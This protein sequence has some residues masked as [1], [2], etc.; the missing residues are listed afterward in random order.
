MMKRKIISSLCLATLCQIKVLFGPASN[1]DR[2]FCDY[3]RT[4]RFR[5]LQLGKFTYRLPRVQLPFKC[6]LPYVKVE[7]LVYARDF[8]VLSIMQ[9]QPTSVQILCCLLLLCSL[10][11]FLVLAYIAQH[12]RSIYNPSR[13]VISTFILT[14]SR[15]G[16][17]DTS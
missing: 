6:P 14:I 8:S 1:L 16:V 3:Q 17:P 7:A 12:L 5:G 2:N 11:P 13:T 15:R 9:S 10:Y 4:E